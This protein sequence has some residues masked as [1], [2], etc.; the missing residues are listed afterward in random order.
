MTTPIAGT[1][2]RALFRTTCFYYS[3]S[4]CTP[5][6]ILFDCGAPGPPRA[7]YCLPLTL[8]HPARGIMRTYSGRCLCVACLAYEA[9]STLRQ[10]AIIGRNIRHAARAWAGG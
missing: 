5:A 8:H 4:R 10:N 1:P 9:L 6:D 3:T 7:A 2:S